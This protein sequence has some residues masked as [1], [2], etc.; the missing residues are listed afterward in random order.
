MEETLCINLFGGPCAGKSTTAYALAA[1][2]KAM[3]I[4][5]EL[6]TEFAK[7]LTW[8]E[9]PALDTQMY[10]T[11]NQIW[12]EDRLM[13]KVRVIVTDSP[14]IMSSMYYEGEHQESWEDIVF[15]VFNSRNNWNFFVYN[16]D[17]KYNKVGRNQDESEARLIGKRICQ[18]LRCRDVPFVTADTDTI[19]DIV[20]HELLAEIP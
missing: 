2:L 6:V 9:S 18:M 20:T 5:V 15:E 7:D 13:G 17:K 19:I 11:G 12:R 8:E 14:I 4:N 1:N 3:G 16:S 10:I